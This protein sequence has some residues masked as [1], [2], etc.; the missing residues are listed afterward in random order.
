MKGYKSL[1]FTIFDASDLE[2][3]SVFDTTF[4]IDDN[5]PTN[6]TCRLW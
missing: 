2:E 1:I 4:I 5:E 6:V 3:K